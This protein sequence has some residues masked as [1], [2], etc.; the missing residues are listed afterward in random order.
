MPA[1]EIGLAVTSLRSAIDIVKA[2]VGL[3][4]AESFRARSIELQGIIAEALGQVVE[5]RE[6]QATQLER[7]HALETEV[8]QLKAWGAEK[9]NYE[10]KKLWTG[11]M[12]YM[13]KP[14]TRG[15]EP[16]HWLCPNCYTEGKKSF[17][18]P[19][20]STDSVLSPGL[21][22]YACSRC[23]T[24]IAANGVPEWDPK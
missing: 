8:A 13:L 7:I 22:T 19:Q 4:D 6:A 1:A 3:R 23:P 11:A 24:K 21:K 5:A 2:M 9:Q 10:L 14:E 12:A 20:M 15:A 17:L 16:P 18:Q